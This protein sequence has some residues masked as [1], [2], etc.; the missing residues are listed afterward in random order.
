M[1]SNRKIS[2]GFIV[3][4]TIISAIMVIPV[5]LLVKISVSGTAEVMTPHPSWLIHQFTLQHWVD[6]FQSGSVWQPLIKSLVVATSTMVLAVVLVAPA[7][8][9]ISR[10]SQ[11]VKIIFIMAIFATRMFPTVGLALPIAIQFTSLNLIDTNTGL[12]LADLIGQIPF[13]AWILISTFSAIPVSLEEA[14]SIDGASRIQTLTKVI[15]PIASQ[16]IAVAALYV[17]LNSWNEFTYALYLSLSTKTLPL[18]VYYYIQ[19]G[20]LFQTA[21]YSTILAIPV[22][23]ITFLLQRYLKSEYLSGAVK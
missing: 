1:T 14:A 20:G 18:G 2:F 22:I 17:W 11:T 8:Y 10:L 13:M 5:Y 23:I 7:A 19:R 12:V 6:V 4:V 3:L 15:F 21:A 16:G 9:A